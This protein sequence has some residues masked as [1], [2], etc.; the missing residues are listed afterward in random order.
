MFARRKIQAVKLYRE[1]AQVGLAE[2]KREVEKLEA[3]LRKAAPERFDPCAKM[4]LKWVVMILVCHSV[5]VVGLTIAS[6]DVVMGLV[7][8]APLWSLKLVMPFGLACAVFSA[9]GA[10]RTQWPKLRQA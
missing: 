4:S 2:A 10:F 3:E 8:G 7:H 5:V 6:A 1:T 9:V